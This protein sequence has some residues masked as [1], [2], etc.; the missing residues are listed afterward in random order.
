VR[1]N[2]L[3]GNR[4]GSERVA[5]LAVEDRSE[6][7][8]RGMEPTQSR[9]NEDLEMESGQMAESVSVPRHLLTTGGV[10][11]RAFCDDAR[12]NLS[13]PSCAVPWKVRVVQSE[14]LGIV[15]VEPRSLGKSPALGNPAWHGP[16]TVDVAP[17]RAASPIQA[18]Y[19]SHAVRWHGSPGHDLR[20][21][22]TARDATRHA[23]MRLPLFRIWYSTTYTALLVLTLLL[24]C[25]SPGDTMYQSIRTREI[26][27]L[28]VIGGVYLLTCFVVLLIYATRVYTNRTGLAA[29]PTGYVPVEDGEV[30]RGVRRIV[31]RQ[32]TRAAVVAWDSRPRDTRGEAT[33]PEMTL[34]PIDPRT[35]PWGHI[36][37][38]G[39]ASPSSPDLPSLQY[40]SVVGELPNLIEARAVSLAPP[41]PVLAHHASLHPANGPPL[42]DAHIVALLQRPRAMGLRDYLARLAAFGL[43]Q[44][45]SLGQAFL[46]QYEAARFSCD[47]LTEAEFRS[48]MAVFADI[49]N[50]MT[51]LDPGVVQGARAQPMASDNNSL[52][53]TA[54]SSDTHASF[55]SHDPYRTPQLHR[56]R[57]VSSYSD[58]VGSIV[59]GSHS[60]HDARAPHS[61]HST[62]T[63]RTAPSRRSASSTSLSLESESDTGSIM[64]HSV[65]P[66][67][68][69]L[70]Y[71]Y[72]HQI[73]GG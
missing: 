7:A 65:H 72:L 60:S 29:I 58:D 66:S 43:L 30:G 40:A 1:Y 59:A 25:V 45:P 26:Q 33:A 36:A 68:S 28:F 62:A 47:G 37:H 34:L 35:P 14:S 31:A 19:F 11:G 32:L 54:S 44:P 57:S 70:P 16:S 69:G 2:G 38:A 48:V 63:L 56:H 15:H 41:D 21:C 3:L 17:P 23:M 18:T 20:M 4:C 12:W 50:G 10:P 49:V 8:W 27:K 24:L 53:P 5:G 52:A 67:L 61:L 64:V 9:A 13:G 46:A 42:P 39:W 71:Q 73:D 22:V 51:E 6:A 55:Q